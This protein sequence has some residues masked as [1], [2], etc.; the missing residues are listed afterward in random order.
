MMMLS[1]PIGKRGPEMRDLIFIL[2]LP[3]FSTLELTI[4]FTIVFFGAIIFGWVA[5]AVLGEIGFGVVLNAFLFV[6]GAAIG[7]VI[8]QR[9]GYKIGTNAH[10]TKAI[11]AA[12]SGLCT[13]IVGSILRR[14]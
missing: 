8:W 11:V 5:D 9:L 3:N 7:A 12:G 6:I 13:L 14:I 1:M 10:L 2:G 4:F